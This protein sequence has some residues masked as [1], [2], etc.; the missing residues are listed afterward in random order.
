MKKE[1]KSFKFLA[2]MGGSTGMLCFPLKNI[3]FFFTVSKEV[4]IANKQMTKEGLHLSPLK[5]E[6]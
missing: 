3:R 2:Y 1:V 4:V 5:K 6:R